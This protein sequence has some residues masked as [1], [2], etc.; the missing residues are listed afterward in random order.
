M[1]SKNGWDILHIC[2]KNGVR[3]IFFSFEGVFWMYIYYTLGAK[4]GGGFDVHKLDINY[5]K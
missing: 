5:V 1:G 3:F 2:L 4:L